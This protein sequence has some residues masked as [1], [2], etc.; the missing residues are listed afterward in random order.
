[1]IGINSSS[2]ITK[3]VSGPS[4]VAF[5]DSR[6]FFTISADMS[7]MTRLSIPPATEAFR[8]FLCKIG[9]NLMA[10]RLHLEYSID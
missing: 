1:M 5:S 2:P 7:I 8:A 3:W 6:H 9:G 4:P 10:A